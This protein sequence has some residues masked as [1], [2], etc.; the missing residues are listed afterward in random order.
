LLK[1]N[2]S[3]AADLKVRLDLLGCQIIGSAPSGE[4]ALTLAG[5]LRPD[6]VLM[7]IRLEGAMDGIEAAQQVR[8]RWHLPVVYLTAYADDTTRSGR[9]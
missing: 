1:T 6:L 2:L 5:Q 4:K 9:S 7:D 3:S 8:Q